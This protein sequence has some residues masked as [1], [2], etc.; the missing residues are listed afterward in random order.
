MNVVNVILGI[1]AVMLTLVNYYY[2][3]K[4]RLQRNAGDA[5]NEAE[6]SEFDGEDKMKIAVF[7][8]KQLVPDL[9][10]PLFTDE[11]IEKIVQEVFDKM[12]DFAKK[13]VNK[14]GSED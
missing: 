2:S 7:Q 12:Q 14:V 5:I 4:S 10:K 11:V 8:I 13:Q 6:L 9:F 3:V 1:T